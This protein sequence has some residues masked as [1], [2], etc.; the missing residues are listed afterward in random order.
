MRVNYKHQVLC[1]QLTQGF[2]IGLFEGF[3]PSSNN[4]DALTFMRFIIYI[5]Y[6]YAA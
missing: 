4:Q 2:T 3:S 1:I 5:L 6:L